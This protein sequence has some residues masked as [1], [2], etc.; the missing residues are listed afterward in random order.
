LQ[1][2]FRNG[3]GGDTVKK[4]IAFLFI[5][6]TLCFVVFA[7]GN[8]FR[9]TTWGMNKS[10]VLQSEEGQPFKGSISYKILGDGL[11]FKVK[12][13]NYNTILQYDFNDD[14]LV[15]A[16][17][18]FIDSLKLAQML[19]NDPFKYY[20]DQYQEIKKALAE[21]YGEPIE[22]EIW[23]NETYKNAPESISDHIIKE[24]LILSAIWE[25]DHTIIVL[26]C[27]EPLKSTKTH[28]NRIVYYEKSYYQS[29][30]QPKPNSD[31]VNL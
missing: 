23:A 17:Y 31:S 5:I 7:D 28:R 11:A 30:Q 29:L 13:L 26:R 14:K 8:D 3:M 6:L 24:H 9:N 1:K 2:I 12:V 22:S 19:G 15:T 21:K 18:V 4:I 27:M 16:S 20:T 10:E 25:N